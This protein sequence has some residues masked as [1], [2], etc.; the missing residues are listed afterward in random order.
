VLLRSEVW[1]DEHPFDNVPAVTTQ[2][3]IGASLVTAFDFVWERFTSRL[4]GL[5]DAEYLWQPVTGCWTIRPGDDGSWVMD[6]PPRP[7][8]DGDE[9]FTT[10]AWRIAHLSSTCL[11]WFALRR[12]SADPAAAT[13]APLAADVAA[14]PAYL[15]AT[16]GAWRAGVAG[17]REESWRDALGPGW[18]PY[19]E[20]SNL[21]LALHVF[22]EVV[23]HA[24][25]VGVLR[26]LYRERTTAV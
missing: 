4:D 6:G 5:T 24:A 19:A 10:I 11:E 2:L 16:Y 20:A 25:E 21:D 23:H 14:L 9:R 8:D 12:F 22:D 26:D 1:C 15:D 18:G 3:T 13:T 7:S 17:F